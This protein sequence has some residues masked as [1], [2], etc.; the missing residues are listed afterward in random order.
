MVA[1][2]GGW[3]V[4]ADE[5]ERNRRSIYVFAKRNL[6]YPLFGTFDAPDGNESCSRRHVSTNAPQALMLING[7]ITL[8]WAR[9]FAG[10]VLTETGKD[11]GRLVER[12]YAIALG[13]APTAGESQ[14]ARD[15]LASQ[16]KQLQQRLANN[17][18]ILAP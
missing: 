17:Q 7:K 13:R 18:K 4:T 11:H 12:I 16:Q 15:F 3:K 5:V 1:P 8:D 10:R 6:R 9:A 2:R 14:L